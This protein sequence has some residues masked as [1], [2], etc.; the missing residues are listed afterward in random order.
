[1]VAAVSSASSLSFS[2]W[3]FSS[4]LWCFLISSSITFWWDSSMAAKPLSQVAYKTEQGPMDTV[5]T[6]DSLNE[7]REVLL[8]R[9]KW[10]GK[11][12]GPR[13]ST[14]TDHPLSDSKQPASYSWLDMSKMSLC[15]YKSVKG[16]NRIHNTLKERVGSKRSGIRSPCAVV[17]SAH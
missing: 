12:Q 2:S 1:M 13:F 16:N 7:G 11:A 17:P 5:N 6:Q 3:R 9:V 4:S 10:S 8:T 15:E 14:A